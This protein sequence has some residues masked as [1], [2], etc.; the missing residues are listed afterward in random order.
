L[1]SNIKDPAATEDIWK[2]YPVMKADSITVVINNT[3]YGIVPN[4]YGTVPKDT[5]LSLG[6]VPYF[7]RLRY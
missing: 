6:T 7:V 5:G 1:W 3:K 2:V 4:I